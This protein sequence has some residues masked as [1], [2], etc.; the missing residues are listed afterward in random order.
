MSGTVSNAI[1]SSSH[2]FLD[3]NLVD[4][5][6]AVGEELVLRVNPGEKLA[7]SLQNLTSSKSLSCYQLRQISLNVSFFQEDNPANMSL[8]D[9][10]RYSYSIIQNLLQSQVEPEIFDS[11]RE[12]LETIFNRRLSGRQ[13]S[14]HL[15]NLLTFLYLYS[16]KDIFR[17][18]LGRDGIEI[19]PLEVIAAQISLLSVQTLMKG[20]EW[21]ENKHDQRFLQHL[22]Q[23]LQLENER[24]DTI[25]PKKGKGPSKMDLFSDLR[26]YT[27]SDGMITSEPPC[28]LFEAGAVNGALQMKYLQGPSTMAFA[29][30][31]AGAGPLGLLC[32]AFPPL[33]TLATKIYKAF[34][35]APIHVQPL[36]DSRR[37]DLSCSKTFIGRDDIL[38]EVVAIWRAK[39]HPLLVGAPGVGKTAIME[40]LARQIASGVIPSFKGKVVF[41]GSA[42]DLT[43][44]NMMGT[45]HLQ[46]A[47][48]EILPYKENVVLALDEFHAFVQATDKT[49]MTLVRSI[50]DG[51]QNSLSYCIFAT[52]TEDYEKHIKQD[53]SLERRLQ[54]IHIKP[55]DKD[56]LLY[57]LH[58][59]AEQMS[60]LIPVSAEAMERVY[61]KSNALQNQS[62]LFLREVLRSAETGNTSHQVFQDR[63]LKKAQ[64]DKFKLLRCNPSISLESSNKLSD[65]VF[66]ASEE[67]EKLELECT[68]QEEMRARFILLKQNLIKISKELNPVAKQ[69][70]ED[71]N[72]FSGQNVPEGNR[73]VT[74]TNPEFV[75]KYN[76][77]LKNL[78]FRRYFE[79]PNLAVFVRTY[80]QIF[81]LIDVIDHDFVEKVWVKKQAEAALAVPPAAANALAVPVAANAL[82]VPEAPEAA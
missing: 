44:P 49:L 34:L 78:T 46:R 73:V 66:Q 42:A 77:E 21:A 43:S 20:A 12:Y 19:K 60:P 40:A 11:C 47:V 72:K 58:V 82:A 51:S 64:I 41:T 8:A 9:F 70:L 76:E 67:L 62:R 28:S 25:E 63:G 15:N 54:V 36:S 5:I 68:A 31:L 80:A 30:G 24:T 4:A 57:M 53:E 69:L 2:A 26:N 1:D 37:L 35:D 32:F 17:L 79:L 38:K 14:R 71:V 13:V 18:G 74:L 50:L 29:L 22:W 33:M 48:R 65:D 7:N 39:R 81:D 56:N 3:P 45:P 55:L 6:P 75:A 23:F 52:T 59:D 61:D 27:L 16:C 10:D